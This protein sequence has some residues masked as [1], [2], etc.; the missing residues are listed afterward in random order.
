MTPQKQLEELEDASAELMLADDDDE[1]PGVRMQV[2]A[3]FFH[4]PKD[5]AEAAVE[6]AT[7]EAR[8]R[9]AGYEKEVAGVGARLGELKATLYARLGSGNIN[10]EE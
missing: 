4:T 6:A 2:G 9:L 7:D 5:D 3:A 8:S 1:E 10:L